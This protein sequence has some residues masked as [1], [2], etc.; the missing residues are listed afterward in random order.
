MSNNERGIAL[1]VVLMT[2]AV[3]S[4]AAFAALN[5]SFG[6]Y[7]RARQFF[8]DRLRSRYLAE[9][10]LVLAMER[11]WVNPN[12]PSCPSPGLTGST[13]ATIDGQTVKI[14]VTNCGPD[15]DH[16][17]KASNTVKGT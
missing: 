12:W 3:F 15:R 17:V 14:S 6:G 1:G 2:A 11:L 5:M 13:D 8:A 9:A 7:Q 16:V 10:G 4:I